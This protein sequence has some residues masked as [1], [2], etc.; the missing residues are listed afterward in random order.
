MPEQYK[1]GGLIPLIPETGNGGGLIIGIILIAAI[2]L[3]CTTMYK[4]NDEFRA[5]LSTSGIPGFSGRDYVRYG[6]INSQNPVESL[7]LDDDDTFMDAFEDDDTDDEDGESGHEETDRKKL[8][9][10]DVLR[11]MEAGDRHSPSDPVIRSPA[12]GNKKSSLA[13]FELGDDDEDED[14]LDDDEFEKSIS[15]LGSGAR[16]D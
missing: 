5:F 7:R 2:G 6:N 3:C 9:E 13:K 11:R 10:R 8:A 15:S 16:Y 4:N 12:N 1:C 14:D